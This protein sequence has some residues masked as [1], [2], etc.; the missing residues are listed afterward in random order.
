[1]RYQDMDAVQQD[2]TNYLFASHTVLTDSDIGRFLSQL[3]GKEGSQQDTGTQVR[4]RTLTVRSRR[5]V[6]D[7]RAWL[8][9]G[10]VGL[11]MLLGLVWLRR[12]PG[13]AEPKPVHVLPLR[14]PALIARTLRR[15]P[16]AA[17]KAAGPQAT[18]DNTQKTQQPPATK[19][20]AKKHINVSI[21][22]VARPAAQVVFRFFPARA[23]VLIDGREVA[24]NGNNLVN[25]KVG[26]GRHHLVVLDTISGRSRRVNFDARAGEH[27]NLGTIIVTGGQ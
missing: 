4:Q 13:Q 8:L 5:R 22:Q 11:L 10:G 25:W 27:V 14:Q 19:A 18:G 2:L 16:V 6:M 1:M 21:R 26:P 15:R 12:P 23:S 20:T 9:A 3:M 17:V 7:Y 24:T